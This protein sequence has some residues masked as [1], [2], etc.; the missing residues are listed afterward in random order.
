[1]ASGPRPASS[2]LAFNGTSYVAL[3]NDGLW[4]STDAENWRRVLE[5]DPETASMVD[6]AARTGEFLAVA[7]DT[8]QA[9]AMWISPD[10]AT[11]TRVTA[12]ADFGGASPVRLQSLS[13]RWVLVGSSDAGGGSP[14]QSVWTSTD[15]QLWSR[16]TVATNELAQVADAG[17]IGQTLVASGWLGNGGPSTM[18]AA[19]VGSLPVAFARKVTFG[20]PYECVAWSAGGP[21]G[22]AGCRWRD[23]FVLVRGGTDAAHY[24]AREDGHGGCAVATIMD[25]KP[26]VNIPSFGAC[27]AQTNPA[28]IAAKAGGSPTAPCVPVTTTPWTPGKPTVLVKNQPALDSD[29]KCMCTWLGVISITQAGQITVNV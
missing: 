27:T 21:N 1:V 4:N 19:W 7:H 28:V 10:G 24:H 20:R 22:S 26:M 12:S 15:G 11:W 14:V 5:I 18:G 9:V 3:E 8:P 2:G 6:V 13:G 23:H 17:A 29:S 25:F 16:Q